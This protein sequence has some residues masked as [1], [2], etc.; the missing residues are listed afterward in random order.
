MRKEIMDRFQSDNSLIPVFEG[1]TNRETFRKVP[2]GQV[3]TLDEIEQRLRAQLRYQRERKGVKIVQLANFVG[4][5]ANV[6]RRY[7]CDDANMSVSRMLHVCEILS[8]NPIDLIF[9]SAPH[10][11][12]KSYESALNVKDIVSLILDM[13]ENDLRTIKDFLYSA[14]SHARPEKAKKTA[15]QVE[16]IGN[17]VSKVE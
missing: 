3:L 10:L 15:K 4:I 9:D 17:N 16:N 7:E 12:G 8:I 5:T 14:Y 6:F 1:K 2:F 13:E 11:W